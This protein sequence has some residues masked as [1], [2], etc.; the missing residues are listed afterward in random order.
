MDS[1]FRAPALKMAGWGLLHGDFFDLNDVAE[2]L[3]MPSGEAGQ[4]MYYL[5]TL[6]S[7]ELVSE[8]RLGRKEKGKAHKRIVI[9][10]L[11]LHPEA[12]PRPKRLPQLSKSASL[13]QQLTKLVKLM[14]SPRGAR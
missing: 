1:K 7:V 9:K 8:V 4:L 2:V 13:Q 6:H 11:C 5:R 3:E 12:P 14:P 10:V